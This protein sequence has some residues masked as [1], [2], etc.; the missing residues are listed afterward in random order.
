MKTLRKFRV[1]LAVAV[2]V[3]GIFILQCAN[4]VDEPPLMWRSK[5]ELPITNE[6]FILGTKLADILGGIKDAKMDVLFAG[7]DTSDTGVTYDTTDPTKMVIDTTKG[8]T[9]ILSVL[10]QDSI[11]YDTKQDSM[12]TK[13]YYPPLGPFSL[14]A[15][16]G[17]N[18]SAALLKI[19]DSVTLTATA[20]QFDTVRQYLRTNTSIQR[21]HITPVSVIVPDTQFLPITIKNISAN[22]ITIDSI[23]IQNIANTGVGVHTTLNTG[24]STTVRFPVDPVN[25]IN[26]SN[27][28]PSDPNVGYLFALQVLGSSVSNA[29]V[30]IGFDLTGLKADYARVI[31]HLISFTASLINNYELT[32]TLK[33]NYIDVE[34]GAFHYEIFNSTDMPLSV[35][36]R[37]L[38]LW[39]RAYCMGPANPATGKRQIEDVSE[40]ITPLDSNNKYRADVNQGGELP[41]NPHSGTQFQTPANF[42]LSADRLF[43][44]WIDSSLLGNPASTFKKSVAP[45]EYI[46][47]P[48]QENFVRMVTLSAGDIL[49]CTI[50]APQFTFGEMLGTVMIPYIREGDTVKVEVPFPFNK[51]AK[52]S[53][54]NNFILQ[55]VLAN[56]YLTTKLPDSNPQQ[57]HG[58]YLQNMGVRYMIYN[59]AAPQTKV[60]CSTNFV[61][62]VNNAHFKQRADI[63]NLVN[64]WPDSLRIA[65][66]V[67]I[68]AGTRVRAVNDLPST[69]PDYG[70]YMGRMKI[71]AITDVRTDIFMDWEVADTTNLDLGVDTAFA[72]P[73][74]LKYFNKMLD[75]KAGFVLDVTN[76]TNIYMTLYGLAAPDS[77]RRSLYNMS[78]G[79]VWELLRDPAQAKDLG[80]VSFLGSQGVRIPARGRRV[81]DSVI[82]DQWKINQLFSSDT[83]A[84]RWQARFLP[85][86]PAPRPDA[87]I[88]TDYVEIHS[89]MHLEGINN[90]DSLLIWN[91]DTTGN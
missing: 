76:H 85:Y 84:W 55:K 71:R 47:T 46:V 68:P 88:D 61:N 28:V 54:K 75:T 30:I 24:D 12:K 64:Q 23:N 8:D 31:N 15:A 50:S 51:S 81:I 32:D 72:I 69:D 22:Q 13:T 41:V 6:Q 82:L 77:L 37:Q 39:D 33:V 36:I 78:T 57:P 65:V 21:I 60:S 20:G 49:T 56:I 86:N 11:S 16:P 90:M 63:T 19:S 80:Y 45:V 17:D 53:L 14:A 10:R 25:G 52:D 44:L 87:L 27:V 89:W 40:L 26:I 74:G 59:P 5:I 66:K 70:K 3:A 67:V 73:K 29:D 4:P 58:A 42:N 18:V 62:I 34:A 48:R 9:I 2:A 38:H 79:R 83:T 91:K 43:P 7:I 1:P 35:K